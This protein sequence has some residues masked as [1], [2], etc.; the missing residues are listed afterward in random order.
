M[1]KA[2]SSLVKKGLDKVASTS[3]G[4]AERLQGLNQAWMH[5]SC[6][7]Q[8]TTGRG[9]FHEAGNDQPTPSPPQL[10]SQAAFQEKEDCLFCGKFLDLKKLAKL[11][12]ERRDTVHCVETHEFERALRRCIAVRGADDVWGQAVQFR[13]ESIAGADLPA[14]EA[15]YHQKCAAKFLSR[16]SLDGAAPAG[17]PEGSADEQRERSFKR[18]CDYL[19]SQEECQF[20]LEELEQVGGGDGTCVYTRNYLKQRLLQHYGDDA[21]SITD[22]FGRHGAIVNVTGFVGKLL[23]ENWYRDRKRNEGDERLRIVK[24]ASQ[25]ILEDIRKS[26]CRTDQYNAPKDVA[27]NLPCSLKLLLETLITTKA[28]SCE[29]V[30]RKRDALGQAL[31]YAARPK[32]YIPPLLC[33]L[34]TDLHSRLGCRDEIDILHS[35]GFLVSYSET[36]RHQYNLALSKRESEGEVREA[37]RSPRAFTHYV[38]DNFDHDTSTLDGH[39]TM[40]VLGGQR[41]VA[42]LDPA[43]EVTVEPV[44]RRPL[45]SSASQIARDLDHSMDIAWIRGPILSGLKSVLV[46]PMTSMALSSEPPPFMRAAF[47]LDSVWMAGRWAG[48][49][50]APSWLGYMKEAMATPGRDF[51]RSAVEALPFVELAATDPNAINTALCYAAA[52]AKKRHQDGCFVTFDQPLYMKA[53][54]IVTADPSLG[55][56]VVRLGGFHLTMSFIGAIA[57]IM[58]GSGLEE[59]WAQVYAVNS[60]KHMVTGKAYS[61]AVRAHFLTQEALGSLLLDRVAMDSTTKT[62]VR[63]IY[64]D[65]LEKTNITAEEVAQ[66]PVALNLGNSLYAAGEQEARNSHTGKLWWQYFKLVGLLRFFIRAE[67]TGD[68]AMHKECV[69]AMLPIFHATGHLPYARAAHLYVQQMEGLTGGCAEAAWRGNFTVRRVS[70]YW[71]GVYTDMVIEQDLMRPMKIRGGLTRRGLT[72]STVSQW[73]LSRRALLEVSAAVERCSGVHSGTSEQHVELRHSRQERDRRDLGKFCEWLTKYPP[74]LDRDNLRVRCLHTGELGATQV[75]CHV[76][77]EIGTALMEKTYGKD[78]ETLKLQLRGR[79]IPLSTTPPPFKAKEAFEIDT[80]FLFMKMVTLD[81]TQ[82]DL[83][84]FL[85]YELAPMPPALFD[86]GLMRHNN[87]ASL[88][89][90]FRPGAQDADDS[91][92]EE[93]YGDTPSGPS[94]PTKTVLDGGHLLHTVAWPRHGGGKEPTYGD[95][96]LRYV[97]HVEKYTNPT[98]VFDGYEESWS[99]KWETQQRRAARKKPCAKFIVTEEEVT[100]PAYTREDYLSSA[101]NKTGLI[102]LLTEKLEGARVEVLQARA[103]ADVIVAEKAMELDQPGQHVSVIARD[104]DIVAILIARAGDDTGITVTKPGTATTADEV[105]CIRAIRRHLAKQGLL[106]CVLLGHAMSGCDTT[107]AIYTKGKLTVWKSLQKSHTLQQHASLFNDPNATREEI[108]EAGEQLMLSLYSGGGGCSTLN[109]LR[110]KEYNEKTNTKTKLPSLATLPP[111]SAAAQQHSFRVYLQVQQWLG[112]DLDPTAWGWRAENGTLLPIPTTLPAVPPELQGRL[113]CKCSAL[114]CGVTCPCRKRGAIC[115]STCSK[116]KGETCKN[117]T[118]GEDDWG[119]LLD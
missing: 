77:V 118:E 33:A 57:H 102:T 50:M 18:I 11:P 90:R 42:L 30:Q 37:Q 82:D 89:R 51:P 26:N 73:I 68:W 79:V 108:S 34:T 105:F 70:G 64:E 80:Q 111:T 78:F 55:G 83:K 46:Q 103:D 41:I 67:R 16:R 86:K 96:C 61:R 97:Q 52:D 7:K 14:A 98:V 56:V 22:G 71:G 91:L 31:M 13:L 48:A 116:C 19:D 21:I 81:M 112:N 25:I 109:D 95:V 17:R 114:G 110:Y 94:L 117:T 60:V 85:T 20:S 4:L 92:F 93:P 107:S 44:P 39:G 35:F 15:K 9:K 100:S 6:Y 84:R 45:P 40:H 28:R 74:F 2:D 88:T 1:T 24:L 38:F 47:T 62:E 106:H 69:K 23:H 27:G 115:D 119:T 43:A 32:S 5:R 72:Q 10:R 65:F 54:K 113:S 29:A 59:L 53:M 101:F 87:K 36:K 63:E 12:V 58:S 3:V 75:N 8:C 49:L 66:S 99:T 104:T 76:A